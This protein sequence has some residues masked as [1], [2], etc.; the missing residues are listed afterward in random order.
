MLC[1]LDLRHQHRHP[2]GRRRH[3]RR[4]RLAGTGEFAGIDRR[5]RDRQ[6]AFDMAGGLRRQRLHPHQPLPRRIPEPHM[7]V[8]IG[9]IGMRL[10][11]PCGLE[12]AHGAANLMRF[13]QILAG[14]HRGRHQRRRELQR[15]HHAVAGLVAILGLQFERARRQQHPALTPMRR[16]VDLAGG[17]IGIENLERTV[18]IALG[19]A[20]AEN[21]MRRPWRRRRALQR[22]LG[23]RNRG[24][25]II[26]ALRLHEQ[27]AQAEQPRL[28]ALGHGAERT[29]RAGTIAVELGRLRVEQQRQRFLLGIAPRHL[30]M[31]SRR[32][33]VAGADR[34][35]AMGDGM[36]APRMPPLAVAAPDPVRSAPQ[37]AHDR[38]RQHRR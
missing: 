9:Q 8:A 36:A 24:H 26:G 16:P 2:L 14:E 28:L 20:E 21:G 38:P 31:T 18:P 37:R 29:L 33:S 6:R 11:Q 32:H 22:L 3:E 5:T 25:R 30:G 27:P 12:D 15:L 35:Q 1:A 17:E 4:Q 23:N 10:R 7:G 34:D 13:A 19:A